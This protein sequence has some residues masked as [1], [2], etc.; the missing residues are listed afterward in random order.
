VASHR[1]VAPTTCPT[2]SGAERLSRKAGE[3]GDGSLE[4]AGAHVAAATP[5]DP[6][7]GEVD[8]VALRTNARWWLEHPIRG[9][10]VAGSTGEAVFLDEDERRAIVQAM[11]SVVPADRLLV[12]GTGAESTRATIRLTSTVAEL[13]ADAVLVM[14]PAFFRDAM[15]PE[16]LRN[17]FEAVADA[18]PVPVI[19]YQ[20]PPRFSTLDLA[21]G[22]ITT[23]AEH[24]NI[25][26]LKDSRG[27][28]ELVGRL[29][30][31]CSP[32]FQVLVGS[33]AH[34]YASLEIGATGGIL[35]VANLL[36]GACAS[37][38]TAYEKGDHSLTGRLQ[39]RL[40]PV[41]EGVVSRFGVAGVKAGLDHLGQVGGLP[42][43]PLQPL[44]DE[45]RSRVEDVLDA[46]GAGG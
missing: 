34:L 20:V 44:K 33:G 32:D 7:T 8:L 30:D 3:P 21:T 1:G 16:V 31:A 10:V 4:L 5:F 25:V 18:S 37:L 26:G 14:P 42:R 23:L 17:H 12:A 36:P 2:S 35:G 19:L 43:P 29:V 40:G 6:V 13:G 39:E 24:E 22:L 46:S 28:L 41:H 9:I 11:R 38:I 15:T 27:D 45:D